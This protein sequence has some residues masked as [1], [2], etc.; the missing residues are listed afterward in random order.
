MA[1]VRLARSAG[2]MHPVASLQNFLP[3]ACVFTRS[4]RMVPEPDRSL[5]TRGSRRIPRRKI[6]VAD[7]DDHVS[8]QVAAGAYG[9]PREEDPHCGAADG[10]IARDHLHFVK[11]DI[12]RR[13]C[14]RE[15]W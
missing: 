14:S 12:S 9:R 13:H 2:A 1:P 8:A 5:E 7:A 4:E 3:G 6:F 11:S 10:G 15:H